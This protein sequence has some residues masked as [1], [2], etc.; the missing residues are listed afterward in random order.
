MVSVPGTIPVVGLQLYVTGLDVVEMVT[1][2]AGLAQVMDTEFA[3]SVVDGVPASATTSTVACE[4]AVEVLHPLTVLVTTTV[5]TPVEE[6]VI[7]VPVSVE[8]VGV[9]QV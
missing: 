7:G 4:E 3:V 8:E 6:L 5:Y 2:G 1:L 9:I